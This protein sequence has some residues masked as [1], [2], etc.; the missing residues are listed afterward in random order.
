[1][2]KSRTAFGSSW[3]CETTA[4]PESFTVDH[5]ASAVSVMTSS[6]RRRPRRDR[7]LAILASTGTYEIIESYPE[8]KYLPSYLVYSRHGD[9]MFHVLFAA[10][11]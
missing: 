1:M 8:D 9:L 4:E 7:F 3:D 2:R 11:V 6:S 10:D 5:H